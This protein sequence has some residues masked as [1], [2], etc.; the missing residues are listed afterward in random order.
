MVLGDHRLVGTQFAMPQ[1]SPE[2]SLDRVT[3][4]R[5][6]GKASS[7]KAPKEPK[8]PQGKA[9]EAS[10]RETKEYLIAKGHREREVM[11]A[12]TIFHLRNYAAKKGFDLGPLDAKYADAKAVVE[13]ARR[14]SIAADEMAR[15]ATELAAKAEAEARAAALSQGT[16]V[17][18]VAPRAREEAELRRSGASRPSRPRRRWCARPRPRRRP[19]RLQR[20]GPPSQHNGAGGVALGR[21][22]T[23]EEAEGARQALSHRES[24]SRRESQVMSADRESA[25]TRES[26]RRVSYD[27]AAPDSRRASLESAASSVPPTPEA[28]EGLLRQLSRR[29]SS[30]FTGTDPETMKAAE[31]A[32]KELARRELVSDAEK[33][34]PGA[35]QQKGNPR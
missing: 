27:S 10:Y 2:L 9:T 25:F 14:A 33:T 35:R 16:Q 18:P 29:I 1:R 15:K 4:Y 13:Q 30:V 17:S 34:G 11:D 12:P 20:R 6:E 28:Q 3:R 8:H 26:W 32:Q 21:V 24:I 22:L 23:D 19:R 7:P 5:A 31:E